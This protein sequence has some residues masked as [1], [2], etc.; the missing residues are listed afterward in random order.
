MNMMALETRMN[1]LGGAHPDTAQSH[2]NLALSLCKGGI[3]VENYSI[4][5]FQITANLETEASHE[6]FK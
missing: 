1:V 5:V 3:G 6:T 4:S 2:A